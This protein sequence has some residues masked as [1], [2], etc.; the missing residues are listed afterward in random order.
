MG[1]AKA[2]KDIGPENITAVTTVI[3]VIAI[4]WVLFIILSFSIVNYFIKFYK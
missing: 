3:T 2:F 1:L 4:I